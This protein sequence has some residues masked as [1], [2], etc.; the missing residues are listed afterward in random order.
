MAIHLFNKSRASTPNINEWVRTYRQ[1][2]QAV[3]LDV[4]TDEEYETAGRIPQTTLHIPLDELR[5]N[6]HRLDRSK[7]IYVNCHSGLRSYI[8]CRIL[9]SHGY[10]CYNFSGG[11][12]F[13]EE[14]VLDRRLTEQAAA[15][16]MD[17]PRG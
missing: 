8:A 7:K 3:L 11:F 4:R 14:V 5:E 10:D 15:C 17:L 12:R 9:A 1:D 13:Y 2:P 6:L 16:G